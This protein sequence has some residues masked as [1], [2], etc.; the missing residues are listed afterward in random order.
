[1]YVWVMPW[2]GGALALA[3]AGGGAAVVDNW[4]YACLI[5]SSR[6]KSSL[7]DRTITKKGNNYLPA[8]K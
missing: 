3:A 7:S 4:L 5:Y 1:M 2:Q 6:S 8:A